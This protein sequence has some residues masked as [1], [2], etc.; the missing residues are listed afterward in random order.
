LKVSESN[1]N[2]RPLQLNLQ[3]LPSKE[4]VYLIQL[5]DPDFARV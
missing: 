5:C 4:V 1:R 3:F 2:I